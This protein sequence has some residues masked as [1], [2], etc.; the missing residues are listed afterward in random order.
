MSGEGKKKSYTMGETG[1]GSNKHT[2]RKPR[3]R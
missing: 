2:M 1:V 3:Q